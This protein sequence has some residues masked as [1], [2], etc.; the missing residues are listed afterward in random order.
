M[1]SRGRGKV[2]RKG[3]KYVLVVVER[4]KGRVLQGIRGVDLISE[5]IKFWISHKAY[6]SI[7]FAN[8]A[9]SSIIEAEGKESFLN[10]K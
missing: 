10:I 9:H 6:V 4:E 5:N 3:E 7:G 1:Y 2:P 8:F